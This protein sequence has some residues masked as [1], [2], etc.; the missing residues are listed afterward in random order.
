VVGIYSCDSYNILPTQVKS[1]WGAKGNWPLESLDELC[2]SG[3]PKEDSYQEIPSSTLD[4]PILPLQR[5]NLKVFK[6]PPLLSP[7]PMF[8][9]TSLIKHLVSEEHLLRVLR[10]YDGITEGLRGQ[11]V[12]MIRVSVGE[13]VQF[14]C[15]RVIRRQ[16]S[17]LVYSDR[18]GKNKAT[19]GRPRGH[20][21]SEGPLTTWRID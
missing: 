14:R 13:E 16:A 6:R 2:L 5:G 7:L 15:D 4:R 10:T 18:V 19:V 20:N 3:S 11:S 9:H 1:C 8:E 12:D 21:E 17:E